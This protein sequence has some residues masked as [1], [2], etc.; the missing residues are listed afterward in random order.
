LAEKHLQRCL[1]WPSR[2][3]SWRNNSPEGL[4]NE[5]A[6]RP[7]C[8]ESQHCVRKI[9]LKSKSAARLLIEREFYLT[10]QHATL[11][12]QIH[13]LIAEAWIDPIYHPST[14]PRSQINDSP[15]KQI[16]I[17]GRALSCAGRSIES[18]ASFPDWG[19]GLKATLHQCPEMPGALVQLALDSHFGGEP[20]KF[21]GRTV[22][23]NIVRE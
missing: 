4:R 21:E 2:V 6:L 18:G 16:T 12:A 20:F 19:A 5:R 10:D 1:S 23:F 13:S 8:P 22:D 15:A 3:R 9:T 11:P 7:S 17:K 14:H